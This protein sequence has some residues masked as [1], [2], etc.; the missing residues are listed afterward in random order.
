MVRLTSWQPF[1]S[2]SRH[3]LLGAS[4][5]HRITREQL[6]SCCQSRPALYGHEFTGYGNLTE[7]RGGFSTTAQRIE[8]RLARRAHQIVRQMEVRR[9]A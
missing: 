6:T 9:A 4:R 8:S 7:L 3:P 5:T 2:D 1:P